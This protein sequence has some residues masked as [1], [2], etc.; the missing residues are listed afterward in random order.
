MES[1]QTIWVLL[2]DYDDYPKTEL[3]GLYSTEEKCREAFKKELDK[4]WP[5]DIVTDDDEGNG[6]RTK[7]ECIQQMAFRDDTHL[8]YIDSEKRDID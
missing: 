2:A 1:K 5:D 6:G 4:V 7:E 3:I 8:R